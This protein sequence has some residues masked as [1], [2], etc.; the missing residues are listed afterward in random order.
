MRDEVIFFCGAGVSR[1]C[2]SLPDFFGLAKSVS[3]KLGVAPDSP[4]KKLVEEA[5]KIAIGIGESGL[6]SADRIFGLL[7]R[8]FVVADIHAAVAQ[9]L[10]PASDVELTAHQVMLDLAKGHDG[11]VRLVTTNFDRLFESCDTTLQCWQ[12]PRLPDP[13]RYGDLDGIV[14]LHGR[15]NP[16][17]TGAEGDGFV[18]SSSEFGRAY[19]SEAWATAFIRSILEKYLVLFVGYT[20]DDPPVQYLLEALNRTVAPR[21]AIYAFQS[22]DHSDAESKWLHKG[23]QPIAYGEEDN[24]RALWDTLTAWSERAHDVEE[25]YQSIISMAQRGPFAR[26]Q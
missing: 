2:A 21:N 19:L 17:Y 22:G 13:L 14:H 4:A 15:V 3:E 11:K 9:S 7:E 1:A 16:N 6:I 26:P 24:H 8:E 5:R 10:L 18:L 23:V 12:P 20:A 25:W